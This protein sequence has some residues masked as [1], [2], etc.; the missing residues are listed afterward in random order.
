MQFSFFSPYFCHLPIFRYIFY[1]YCSG[2]FVKSQEERS[3]LQNKKIA[4][5][6]LQNILYQM[7]FNEMMSN[8][9]QS[10]KLQIGNMNRK[11]F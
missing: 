7:E 9:H 5:K 1:L 10:R 3:Q 4:L 2:L 8:L 6:K 11:V